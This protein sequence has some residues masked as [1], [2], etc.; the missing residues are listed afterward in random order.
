[1]DKRP[2]VLV[3]PLS[4]RK[5][6]P[7]P[8]RR[9]PAST[10]TQAFRF[11][12]VTTSEGIFRFPELPIG[13]YELVAM[14]VGFQRLVRNRIDLLTGHTLELKLQLK[15]GQ[16]TTRRSLVVGFRHASFLP[17]TTLCRPRSRGQ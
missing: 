7:S 3:E 10:W 5:M 14:K 12:A 11:E 15:A 13:A 16:V 17:G 6:P 2:A 4:I 1:M 8:A 9:Y